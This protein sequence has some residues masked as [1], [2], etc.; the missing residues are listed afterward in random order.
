MK[1]IQTLQLIALLVIL[2]GPIYIPI[3]YI[4]NPH[5]LDPIPDK[6]SPY[7]EKHMVV[8]IPS[9]NNER[10]VEENLSSVYRQNY[11]NY[12]VIYIDDCSSDKTFERAEQIVKKNHQEWR[13]ALIKND[14]RR[15]ALANLYTAIHSCKDNE[16]VLTLDGDDWFANNYVLNIIGNIYDN[17]NIWLTYGQYRY[18][19]A[20][21]IGCGC[22]PSACPINPDK[23]MQQWAFSHLRTFYAWLFKSIKLEDLLY[24]G[25][26]YAMTWDQ[27]MMFPMCE[28]AH[29]RVAYVP[30]VVYMY[31]RIN[32]INDDKV[33]RAL[34][35]KLEDYIKAQKPYRKIDK[36]LALDTLTEHDTAAIVIYSQD[37]P[38][39]L[40]T[41][42]TSLKS[43]IK[44]QTKTHVLYLASAGKRKAY[45]A[46]SKQFSTMAFT[47][48]TAATINSALLL[49]VNK[50]PDNYVIIAD[51]SGIITQDIDITQCI[52]TMKKTAT[53][54]FH[55]ALDYR[56]SDALFMNTKLPPVNRQESIC[57]WYPSNIK[58][59]QQISCLSMT[60][61]NKEKLLEALKDPKINTLA[62]LNKELTTWL[63]S[64][65]TLGLMF[66]SPRIDQQRKNT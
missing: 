55:M 43:H 19:P 47:A 58:Q 2:G 42:L 56:Q 59:G 54:F 5:L 44:N 34:Q 51:D 39:Q 57:A 30:Y 33:N 4:I 18:F 63:T 29:P 21:Q 16:I 6:P 20:G 65:N 38:D 8:I 12:R 62:A 7:P 46:L 66:E 40:K 3:I 31:N 15:G 36:P 50:M 52:S 10:W 49:R 41:M 1:G 27:A 37:N 64:T 14:K 53:Q 48:I 45:L 13:T 22:P 32:P 28:M 25:Y 23:R 9:Y 26:F 11:T 24:D 61:W 35:L 17:P 60:L